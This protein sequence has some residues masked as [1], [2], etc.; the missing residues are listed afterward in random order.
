[1]TGGL[2]AELL[3]EATR[4]RDEH[5]AALQA[6]DPELARAARIELSLMVEK[7]ESGAPY[8][9]RRGTELPKGHP[10]RQQGRSGDLLI[11]TG[12]D[13]LKVA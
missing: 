2:H 10:A 8:R 6:V 11:L 9:I 7:L 3:A 4:L 5:A 13:T 1:M 12:G